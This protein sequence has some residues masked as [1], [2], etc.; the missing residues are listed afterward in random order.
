MKKFCTVLLLT[1]LTSSV[2]IAAPSRD[3]T[4]IEAK[5]LID[6]SRQV[7]ILDVRTPQ[8]RSQGYIQGSVLIPIDTIEK[9]IGEIPKKRT[10][11]VYCAV[12]SRSRA[13]SQALSGRGYQDVY[14]MK[15]GIMGWYRNGFPIQR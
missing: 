4:S 12:G 11:V 15:D 5:A 3:I 1:L 14:N 8:E 10:I 2:L 13:V 6:K 9:R 7:F